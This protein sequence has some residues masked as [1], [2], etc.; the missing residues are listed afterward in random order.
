MVPDKIRKIS[1]II[2]VLVL[3]FIWGNSMMNAS[4]SAEISGGVTEAVVEAVEKVTGINL[5][6]RITDF[7][8][9]KAAHFT[10]FAALGFFAVPSFISLGFLPIAT[11]G[12]SVAVA[13]EI[14]QFFT[15]G[16]GPQIRD[17]CIDFAGFLTGA[18]V[19]YI[20]IRLFCK[21][22]KSNS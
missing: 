9:R 7:I 19:V 21:K 16:R 14:I 3:I 17:V 4:K 20:L 6:G 10:Q 8:V 5:E 2:F 13:D 12:L 1:R 11:G 15:P 18:A 22:Y